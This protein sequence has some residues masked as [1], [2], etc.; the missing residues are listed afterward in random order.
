MTQQQHPAPYW[1]QQYQPQ[2]PRSNAI[3]TT[4]SVIGGL[5]LV[6]GLAGGFFATSVLV[7]VFTGGLMIVGGQAVVA[8]LVIMALRR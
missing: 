4:L 8:A 5:A 3:V 6:L 7:S 1:P 2:P